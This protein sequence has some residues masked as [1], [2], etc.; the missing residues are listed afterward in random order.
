M[1]AKITDF[2]VDMLS[3]T[4]R[5]TLTLYGDFRRQYDELRDKD[6]DIAVKQFRPKRSLDAN[7]YMWVLVGKLAEVMNLSAIEI[8]RTAIK[9][10]GLW[11]D[12]ELEEKAAETISHIWNEHGIGWF[13]EKVDETENGVIVRLYYGSSCYNSKQMARLIDYIVQDCENVGIETM[14]PAELAIMTESWKGNER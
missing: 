10:V 11:R 5:L 6:V 4:Q 9:E 3:H 13:T 2:C 8:Y 7:A 14:T 1:K 12:V